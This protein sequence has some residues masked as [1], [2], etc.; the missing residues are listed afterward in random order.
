MLVHKETQ[1]LCGYDWFK[2]NFVDLETDI[3]WEQR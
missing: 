2:W 1:W 3:L